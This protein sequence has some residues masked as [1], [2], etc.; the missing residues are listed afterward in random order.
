MTRTARH[1]P[2][3]IQDHAL[4]AK[5]VTLWWVEHARQEAQKQLP[6]RYLVVFWDA[7]GTGCNLG[8]HLEPLGVLKAL[9]LERAWTLSTTVHRFYPPS[10]EGG[11]SRPGSRV[12]PQ[13]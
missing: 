6:L 7:L 11:R 1:A 2:I 5:T 3:L 12:P 9:L 10:G 4:S 8:A 13:N